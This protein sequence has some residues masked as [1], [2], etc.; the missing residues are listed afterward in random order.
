M[1]TNFLLLISLVLIATS[2]GPKSKEETIIGKWK[3]ESLNTSKAIKGKTPTKDEELALKLF[4]YIFQGWTIEFFKDKTMESSSKNSTNSTGTY[5]F[6]NDGKYV[7]CNTIDEKGK[8]DTL[9]C[10]IIE[11]TNDKFVFESKDDME[12]TFKRDE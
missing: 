5:E 4:G 3:Y 12:V 11:L 8:K 2:C 7:I 6:L 1:K 10:L 9:K